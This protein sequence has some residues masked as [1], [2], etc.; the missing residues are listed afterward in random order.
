M[1]E[2][3]P[4]PS[5]GINLSSPEEIAMASPEA[6]ALQDNAGSPQDPLPEQFFDS[7]PITRLRSQQAPKDEVQSVTHD[8]VHYN[9]KEV[10]KFS[11]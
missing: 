10:L 3:S 4:P 8:E 6:V 1:K 2:P 5:G 11:N 9:A 7:R